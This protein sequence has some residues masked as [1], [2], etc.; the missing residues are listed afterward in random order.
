MTGTIAELRIQVDT[1]QT[2]QG[3]AALKEFGAAT[4]AVTKSLKDRK[5]AEEQLGKGATGS[6]AGGDTKPIKDISSA[7]DQQVKKLKNLDDQRKALSG[8]DLKTT[9]PQEY[10]RLN[11]VIDANIEMVKR[12]GNALDSLASKQQALVAIKDAASAKEAKVAADQQARLDATISGLSRQA[13]AQLDYNKT[14]EQLNAAR[15]VGNGKNASGGQAQLSEGA[16]ASWVK[17]AQAQR[18]SA[19]ALVDNSKEVERAKGKLEQLTA[20]LGK[21]ERA[22]YRYAQAVKALDTNVKLGGI[23]QEQYNAKLASFA[24]ARDKSIAT[25]QNGAASEE[26]FAKQLRNT[27]TA[28]DPV[29]AATLKYNAAIKTLKDG[30]DNEKIS[31]D[32]YNRALAEHKVAL[33]SVKAAQI[34]PEQKQAKQYQEA[35][36]RLLP[37]NSQLR[38][39]EAA[40][41]TLQAAQAS[42]KVVTQEQITAH[43]AATAALAAERAEI[44]RVTKAGQ[45]RGNSAKQDAAALRGV[46]AQFTDIVVSL[47]GGQ[48]PLTVLLQQGGQLKDMFGGVGQAVKAMGGYLLALVSNPV[49]LAVAALGAVAY[50]FYDAAKSAGDINKALLTTGNSFGGTAEDARRLALTL[51][52]TKSSTYDAVTAITSLASAGRGAS[53]N[54]NEIIEVALRLQ[55]VAGVAVEETVASFAKIAKDPVAAVQELSSKYGILDS[56]ILS[57]A[58]QLTELG[59]TREAVSL[60]ESEAARQTKDLTDKV[61]INYNGLGKAMNYFSEQYAKLKSTIS[62]VGIAVDPL[63]SKLAELNRAMD[64]RDRLAP[65]DKERGKYDEWIDSL[66]VELDVLEQKRLADDDSIRRRKEENRLRA[67]GVVANAEAA[68]SWLSLANASE[69]YQ[70]SLD[71]LDGKIAET[72]VRIASGVSVEGDNETLSYQLKEQILLTKKLKEAKESETKKGKGTSTPLDTT[73]SNDVKNKLSILRNDYDNYYKQVDNLRTTESISESEASARKVKTLEEETIKVKALYAEQLAAIQSL[74]G[75]KGNSKAQELKLAKQVSDLKAAEKKDIA[76]LEAEKGKEVAT[77]TARYKTKENN[78]NN[79]VNNL[80]NG[81][82]DLKRQGDMEASLVGMGSE[83]AS[84]ESQKEALRAASRQREQE[85]QVQMQEGSIEQQADLQRR[86]DQEK[87]YLDKSLSQVEENAQK[88]KAAESSWSNGVSQGYKDWATTAS[89]VSGQ[90]ASVV[91][92]AFD[93]MTDAVANFV[94]TGKFNFKDFAVSIL[95]EMAKMATKIAASQILMSILGS[96]AGAGLGGAANNPASGSFV[97]PRQ[98]K[99]GVWSG[100]VQKFAKGGAFTNSVYNK[101]TPF[102]MGG[103]FGGGMGVMGE[104][105]PEAIMPLTR[106]PDGS[107]GVRSIGGGSKSSSGGVI[108]NISIAEGGQTTTDSNTNGMQQFGKEIGSFVEQKYNQL[109]SKDLKPGGQVYGA[110]NAR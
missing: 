104:A 107:L 10:I 63:E 84:L 26:R 18:D 66:R 105:G 65:G 19:Y 93:S 43:K 99:G 46:P 50:A 86:L 87:I 41:R 74:S 67:E 37:Y 85:L 91:S 5:A 3:T 11:Q 77:E 79:Y 83:A 73:D 75:R 39:L 108:V 71:I 27:V 17:L 48:A 49:V 13:K 32:V 12:Q 103:A 45:R 44:D 96:F 29:A 95:S 7:I 23:S 60:I 47:Q 42:G 40:E 106:G 34:S 33:E 82:D 38:N 68:S 101:P 31:L 36:D 54:F 64:N 97:G 28:F 62:N 59:R 16:Y 30:L 4:N 6:G 2:V 56:T 80:K 110:I 35:L 102:A 109:M 57:H 25:A 51:T 78:F 70:K 89:N 22:E 21:I 1:T 8:S 9:N 53:E 81:L 92:G 61:V 69:R 98:A 20:S 24:N 14:L 55:K 15:D 52:D 94:I 88:K 72:R 58:R 76:D 100:G 90:V